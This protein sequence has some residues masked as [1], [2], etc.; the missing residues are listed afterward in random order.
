MDQL[1]SFFSLQDPNVRIVL[2]G[3]TLI[4]ISSALVGSFAFLRKKSLVGDAVAH[5]LLPGVVMAFMLTGSKNPW[6]LIA[7]ALLAG[8]FSIGWMDF[9]IERTKLKADASIALVLS[10]MFGLGILLLTHVQ[11]TDLGNQ[12]GLDK[13]LFGK[14]ASLTQT[15][16]NAFGVVTLI[17]VVL[18]AAFYKELKLISFNQDFG[19]SVGLPIKGLNFLL[20][21]LLVLAIITGIQ[22]VGVVLMAALLIAPV[23]AARVWTHKLRLLMFIAMGMAFFSSIVGAYVSYTVANM[24][25]GPWIV[26]ILTFFTVSSLMFAPKKGV[27]ARLRMQ[28]QNQIKINTENILKALYHIGEDSGAEKQWVEKQELFDRRSFKTQTY[29]QMIVV[30]AKRMW[31]IKGENEKVKLTTTGA[32]EAARVV[33][34]HRLWEMYLTQRMHLKSDHIH[35]NAETIEHIITPEIEKELME[36]LGSPERDP[37]NSKI[38]YT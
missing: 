1:V 22:A 3:M 21:T 34:L 24:P 23:A 15:D 7:G 2:I 20:N 16:V 8:W 33:R 37:H 25:T 29:E 35:P 14:A 19:Q 18:I 13:F 32:I 10:V 12:S 27:L 5:S 4:S 38:P 26:V 31:V 6:V 17:I 28:K 30:L 11:H 9:L 36:E